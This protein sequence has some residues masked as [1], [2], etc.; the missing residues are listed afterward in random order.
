MNESLENLYFNW[1]CAKVI[2]TTTPAYLDLLRILH[3][4]EFVWVILGD[5]NR[6]EDGIEL[7]DHFLNESGFENELEWYDE[8][9]SVL[10][11]LISFAYRAEFQT[12]IPVRDWFW[13]FIENL[14]L[15]DF[16]TV[17]Q[18]EEE[19]IRELLDVLVWRT[20]GKDGHGGLFPLVSSD[21]DQRKVEIWYQF[22]EY[23]E[24]QDLV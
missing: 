4:T 18:R 24:N 15:D 17:T 23:L 7:R 20:Y 16:R 14:N 11:V 12:E 13:K 22:C 5:R 19:Y 21:N 3:K 8:S 9:C 6:A 10:E 2:D 1:L